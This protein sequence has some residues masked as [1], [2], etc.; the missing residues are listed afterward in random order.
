MVDRPPSF[1]YNYIMRNNLKHQ[2]RKV[3][4]RATS[5]VYYTDTAWETK[6]IDGIKFIPVIKNVGIRETPKLMRKDTLE[7]LK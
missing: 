7:F 3:R 6:E 2:I 4:V 1:G 5:E